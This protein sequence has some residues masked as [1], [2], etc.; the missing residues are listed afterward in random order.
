MILHDGACCP[1]PEP[2]PRLHGRSLPGRAVDERHRTVQPNEHPG[3]IPG[4]LVHTGDVIKYFTG[5]MIDGEEQ[6][7]RATVQPMT[8]KNQQKYPNYYNI[9]NEVGEEKSIK[10]LEGGAWQLLHD[11]EYQLV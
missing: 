11:D 7:L 8:K 3:S 9:L 1:V 10:L 4:R 5:W 2:R 6:W